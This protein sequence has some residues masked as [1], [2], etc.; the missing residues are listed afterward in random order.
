MSDQS[1]L[2][3]AGEAYAA[4]H[5]RKNSYVILKQNYVWKRA[6]IDIIAKKSNKII[7]VEV[8]TRTT[9][10]MNAP[11]LMVPRS[12]QRQIIKAADAFLKAENIELN[13]RFDIISV[14]INSTHKKLHHIEDAF[15]PTLR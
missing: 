1:D 11:A 6:E 4:E 10:F 12:K 14:I 15:Y 7:F 2:G 9:E 13:S 3:K 5:L 8:K